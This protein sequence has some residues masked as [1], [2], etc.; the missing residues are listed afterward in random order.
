MKEL[1]IRRGALLVIILAFIASFAYS[2]GDKL[3]ADTSSTTLTKN[4]VSYDASAQ[5]VVVSKGLTNVNEIY[6]G[7]ASIKNAKYN[8]NTVK[9]AN[10]ANWSIHDYSSTEDTMID[11]SNVSCANDSYFV[12]KAVQKDGEYSD[13]FVLKF[14]ANV[15]KIGLTVNYSTESPTVTVTNKASKTSIAVDKLQYRFANNAWSAMS[16]LDTKDL[17]YRGGSLFV[18]SAPVSYSIAD[19]ASS[20]ASEDLFYE[21]SDDS[22]YIPVYIAGSLAGKEAKVTI[23]SQGA[24][25]SAIFNYATGVISLPAGVQ[26]R[27]VTGSSTS[28]GS[29]TNWTSDYAGKDI[30]F[31]TVDS[32]IP[33][34]GYI[35]IRKTATAKAP[36]SKTRAFKYSTTS[37]PVPYDSAGNVIT[38]EVSADGCSVLAKSSD[39]KGTGLSVSYLATG[40]TFK[41]TVTNNGTDLY[42]FHVVQPGKTLSASS[43][44]SRVSKTAVISSVKPAS[45]LYVRLAA[46]KYT[47]TIASD[48]VYVGT[49]K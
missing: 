11:L 46:N 21:Y 17:T 1:Y 34:A 31:K 14:T 28:A 29:F 8:G 38:S 48:Y 4:V 40:K 41:V 47:G 18:R 36:C 20:N 45:K 35:E 30:N 37:A 23:K 27:F 19:S 13:A 26:S 6:F 33:S 22:E 12:M 42:D 2:N 9:V 7:Q 5:S 15:S 49:V 43:K 44:G 25:P 10:V 3:S 24:M 32:S 16:K 39:K